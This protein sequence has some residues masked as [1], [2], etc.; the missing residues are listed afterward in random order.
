MEEGRFYTGNYT[1]LNSTQQ[2]VLKYHHLN[3]S[4]EL[5]PQGT[6]G[7]EK[8]ACVRCQA[9]GEDC[10]SATSRSDVQD[11]LLREIR[12]VKTGFC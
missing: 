6:K 1:S 10:Y 12:V 2:L 4:L 5:S 3:E 8:E 9:M 11:S 7:A